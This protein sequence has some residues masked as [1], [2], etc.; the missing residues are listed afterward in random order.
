MTS[1]LLSH[2]LEHFAD[3]ARLLA[4]AQRVVAEDGLL[5]VTLP[6][7]LHYSQRVKFIRGRF[8]Y[9]QTGV[10]DATH[11]RFFTF[12]SALRLVRDSGLDVVSTL[13]AGGLSWWRLRN[14]LSSGV[15][16]RLDPVTAEP[17][18]LAGGVP[19]QTA[20]ELGGVTHRTL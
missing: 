2:V 10:I 20:A 8:E 11:L 1:W 19:G 12:Y 7:V 18:V 17:A 6:N 5:A 15:T 14:V 9:T 3:P 16:G 4:E 13:P